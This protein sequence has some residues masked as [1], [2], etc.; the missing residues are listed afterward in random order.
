MPSLSG[1]KRLRFRRCTSTHCRSVGQASVES[2]LLLATLTVALIAAF[3]LLST[4][5][6]NLVPL[7]TFWDR[8]PVP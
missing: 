6:A 5:I 2:A 1:M 4:G 8:L 7:Q 3:R